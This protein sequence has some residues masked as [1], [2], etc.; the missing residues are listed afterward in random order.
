MLEDIGRGGLGFVI[1]EDAEVTSTRRGEGRL[2]GLG[3]ETVQDKQIE[4]L[5]SD[6]RIKKSMKT[7]DLLN[8]R[9]KKVS[10]KDEPKKREPD[11][12]EEKKESQEKPLI[13]PTEAVRLEDVVPTE[14][15]NI[16]YLSYQN[17]RERY[18]QR[19]QR[20][21]QVQARNEQILKELKAKEVKL[22]KIRTKP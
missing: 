12:R 13:T 14:K 10:F 11:A 15:K 16:I 8:A 22:P 18:L 1:K 21:N 6:L 19:E 3:N 5:K 2:G 9:A 17:I 20:S 7:L 4:L